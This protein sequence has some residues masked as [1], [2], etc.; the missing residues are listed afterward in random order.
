MSWWLLPSAVALVILAGLCVFLFV[1]RPP[2]PL[3]P[4]ALLCQV[5]ALIWVSGDLLTYFATTV[6][7]KQLAL[8]LLFTGSMSLPALWWATSI[9]YVRSHHLP[10]PW[11]H[12]RW[13][14]LPTLIGA[15][16]WLAMITNPW[17]GLFVTPIV[18]GRSEYHALS[19]PFIVA[20]IG[21][22]LGASVHFIGLS[23]QPLPRDVRRSAL[24][25]AFSALAP[26]LASTVYFF[27]DWE[28]PIDPVCIGLS[29]ACAAMIWGVYHTGLFSLLP[30]A[31]PELL[32]HDPNGVLLI[33]AGGRLLHW[34][35][36]AQRILEGL[37]LAPE[38][39]FF[40]LLLPE[41]REAGGEAAEVDGPVEL[42]LHL[43]QEPLH[44]RGHIYRLAS[45]DRW[46]R[47]SAAPVPS[48]RGQLAAITVRIED[49]TLLQQLERE[50]HELEARVR[51]ADKLKSLGLLAGGI[52]HDFNNLL[53][54]IRGNASLAIQGRLPETALREHLLEIE[55]AAKQASELTLQLLTYGGS[56]PSRPTRVELPELV[57]EMV[58]LLDVSVS[59][60]ATLQ[61]HFD[62][63]P[64]AVDADP[65]QLRQ[66]VMNLI[67][68]AA[69]AVEASG[70]DGVVALHTRCVDVSESIS[71][72]L[73]GGV[74]EPGR[75][76]VLEV[77]DT[78]TGMSQEVQDRIFDPFFTTRRDGRG[79]G[80]AVV[81]GCVQALQGG[82]EIESDPGAGTTLRVYLPESQHSDA[83]SPDLDGDLD[84][85]QAA[86]WRGE[87]RAL[88]IDDE[89]R[90]LRVLAATL[91]QAGF[92][93]ITAGGG[94]DGIERFRESAESIRFVL[95][96]LSMPDVSG[97]EALREIRRI[98][99]DARVILTSGFAE[100]HVMARLES[101]KLSGFLQKPYDAAELLA[102]V[103]HVLEARDSPGTP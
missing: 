79:L 20:N 101:S 52:A 48:R 22:I 89:P 12:S 28:I 67:T 84:P 71:Q 74:V 30:V 10:W 43:C 73:S 7:Q 80:M 45:S 69:E 65:A 14:M 15:L 47:V 59:G 37:R 94:A 1:R 85:G 25:L 4:V 5:A 95:L 100:S 11:I 31:L 13:A 75:H 61:T 49:V 58:R 40:S 38:L 41:L 36:A 35:P 39:D 62:P 60:R 102:M 99:P 19:T 23:A 56:A 66:L 98:D 32:R 44:S 46:V 42:A 87:G 17:H 103:H 55:D 97:E 96:D 90:M 9:R 88:V 92:D 29:A 77:V 64:A 76:V 33:G 83:P 50:R 27:S 16:G 24:I 86:E 63:E 8:S 21:M 72:R 91:R 57:T 82:I 3:W 2:A 6:T 93:V 70:R 51:H 26:L 53:G 68:N 81:F 18:G 34:N 78:G 54:S